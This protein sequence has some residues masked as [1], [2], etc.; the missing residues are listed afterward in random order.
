[1]K[2]KQ[3]AIDHIYHELDLIDKQVNESSINTRFPLLIE[4]LEYIE[5]EINKEFSNDSDNQQIIDLKKRLI[6]VK[7]RAL[8]KGQELI[9]L[10]H[11]IE[12]FHSSLQKFTEWLTETERYLNH[13]KPVQRRFGLI[14][15][16]LKQIDDHKHFQIQLQTYKEHL[17]DLDKLATHLKFVS[18]KNDSIYIRNSLTAAQTRWQKVLTRTTE[19]TKELQKA[20]H[21]A[22]KNIRPEVTDIDRIKSE[23]NRQASLCTCSKKYDVQQIAEGRYRFG[24]SQSLRLVRILRST[25]MVRVGGGWTAL[26]EFLVRHD[27]C[28]AKGR[29][30]YELHPESYALRDGVAQTMTLFKPRLVTVHRPT[31]L[32]HQQQLAAASATSKQSP[33]VTP[34][35]GSKDKSRRTSSINSFLQQQQQPNSSFGDL[36]ASGDDL[37]TS[38]HVLSD[39]EARPSHIPIL[40]PSTTPGASTLS[41]TSSRESVLSEQSIASTSSAQQRRPSKLP[42]PVI[43]QKKTSNGTSPA[44]NT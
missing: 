30:N 44:K 29:T 42:L 17:I 33:G 25:V 21:D 22:K 40:V 37:S 36:S 26:D 38:P 10:A 1:M 24:E 20:F 32:Y 34:N 3:K 16:L 23:V 27:P 8:T 7:Q 5:E 28:R 43:R 39:S 12:L 2:L 9:E 19:R 11:S 35:R 41:R 18:P 15:T 31:C 6:D 14:Q 13:Q 4:R